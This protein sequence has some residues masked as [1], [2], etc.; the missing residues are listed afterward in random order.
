M[1]A[2]VTRIDLS[3][4]Y[5]D[6]ASL[7]SLV[8]GLRAASRDP[9]C[10]CVTIAGSGAFCLGDDPDE[11]AAASEEGPEAIGRRAR[12]AQSRLVPLIRDMDKPVIAEIDGPAI[13]AGLALALACDVRIGSTEA[14]LG[15]GAPALVGG[16]SFGLSWLLVRTLGPAASGPA[17]CGQLLA[18]PRAL[19]LGLLDEVVEQSQL[20]GRV[21]EVAAE[22][23]AVEPKTLAAIKRGLAGA[24][25]LS[26]TEAIEYESYLQEMAVEGAAVPEGMR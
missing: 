26:L 3:G 5:V 7:V 4:P 16:L 9:D 17:M 10:H 6:D 1:R 14:A 18:A 22:L 8:D 13:G 12:G 15:C 25:E 23:A 2:N 19:A 21:A 11:R 20:P 24:A